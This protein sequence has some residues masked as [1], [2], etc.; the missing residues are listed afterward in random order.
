MP[1]GKLWDSD[2]VDRFT[3]VSLPRWVPPGPFSEV[4][5]KHAKRMRLQPW[6]AF[7]T[8]M[9]GGI[10][11]ND[12]A[13]LLGELRPPPGAP[14]STLRSSRPYQPALARSRQGAVISLP[15]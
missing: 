4:E 10:D 2:K 3:A 9:A 13:A 14:P 5:S 1:R 12:V 7:T 6:E 11:P 15:Q 8:F